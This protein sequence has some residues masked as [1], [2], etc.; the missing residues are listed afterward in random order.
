[1]AASQQRGPEKAGF[2]PLT[3]LNECINEYVPLYL[4]KFRTTTTPQ[5]PQFGVC[6]FLGQSD[7]ALSIPTPLGYISAARG[8]L[9]PLPTSPVSPLAATTSLS[10]RW[11]DSFACD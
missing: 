6:M 8:Q 9:P 10:T 3:K 4:Q 2:K 7:S 5:N 1:M 11:K